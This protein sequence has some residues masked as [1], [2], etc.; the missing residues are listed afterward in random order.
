MAL[1]AE[2]L[3]ESDDER[4][5]E[6]SSVAFIFPTETDLH[7]PFS[8]TFTIA[9]T[10]RA[11]ILT[12]FSADGQP[13]RLHHF[14]P[15]QLAA[16]LPESY[17]AAAPPE[18]EIKSD[19]PWLPS[20]KIEE[21]SSEIHQLWEQYHDPVLFSAIDHLQSAAERCFGLVSPAAPVLQLPAELKHR[22][23]C[24]N[25]VQKK[26][27]F[28][29]HTYDCGICLE[30]RKGT[31]CHRIRSC[32][33]VFCRECLKDYFTASITAGEIGSVQCSDFKCRKREKKRAPPP[34]QDNG[35]GEEQ[36]KPKR[37]LPPPTIPPDELEEI[38]IE[39]NMVKRYVAMKKKKALEM[40]PLTIY[41]PRTFCQ[42]PAK[43]CVAALEREMQE[44]G[45]GYWLEDLDSGSAAASPP[46]RSLADEAARKADEEVKSGGRAR[47]RLQVCS[48]C[49]FAF[50]R[51]C[52]NSW[53]GDYQICKA[54]DAELTPEEKANEK[55]LEENTTK[56]PTCLSPVLKSH[57][58]NHMVPIPRFYLS[59]LIFTNSGF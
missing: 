21:L 37:E 38:G 52:H 28:E 10:P 9:V 13:V 44:S 20:S 14:P 16:T 51:V 2:S 27:E 54:K 6:L 12:A 33:H 5:Q 46:S 57:G 18:L 32:G 30:P 41:C 42:G 23:V 4:S 24:Y 19:P 55:Y 59:A 36:P 17:P 1:T 47:P 48:I 15:L 26:K 11:P 45:N 53:H 43:S 39:G 35:A 40:D 58:C 29:S 22:L 8:A 3:A 31:V 50:C 34:P 56:C 7:T 49:T 25:D